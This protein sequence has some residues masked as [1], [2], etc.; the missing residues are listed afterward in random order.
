MSLAN[1]IRK[2][3]ATIKKITA[4]LQ[5]DVTWYAWTG[6]NDAGEDVW[7]ITGTTLPALSE[8]KQVM[9]RGVNGKELKNVTMLTIL[10][11]VTANGAPHREEPIDPR[12]KF[13]LAD[14][15]SG[16]IIDVMG[17]DDPSTSKPYFYQVLLG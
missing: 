7:V 4:T 9:V 13:I 3:V 11:P 6:W 14:G 5:V 12:D 1:V 2:G 15:S 10:Q 17:L 16:P 8:K